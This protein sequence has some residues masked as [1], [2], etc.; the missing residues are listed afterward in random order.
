MKFVLIQGGKS[1]S[2]PTLGTTK[3]K[4]PVEERLTNQEVETLFME[5]AENFGK[6]YTHFLDTR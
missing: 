3:E 1:E 4:A 2:M 5:I 6:L